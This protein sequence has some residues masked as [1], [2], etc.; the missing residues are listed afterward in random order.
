[1]LWNIPSL[2]ILMV[3]IIYYLTSKQ[4]VSTWNVET[5]STVKLLHSNFFYPLSILTSWDNF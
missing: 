1:M 2:N 3:R 5:I 4:H